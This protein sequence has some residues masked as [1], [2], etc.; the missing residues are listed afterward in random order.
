[1]LVCN[2]VSFMDPMIIL[3]SIRRPV[4]FVMYYKIFNIPLV[5]YVFRAAKAIPIAGAKEDPA[6]MER[7]FDEVDKELAAGHLVC[8][9]PEGAI[10]RDGEIQPFRPGVEK[11]LARRPVPV[12]P[13]A[14]RNLWG[15]IFSRRDS[16]VGRMRLPRR[17]RAKI[18]LV[19]DK[20]IPPE[21][22]KAA[23]LEAKVRELRGDAA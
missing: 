2:H 9:F 23:V 4:R 18:E 6:I 17:F 19:I 8:I 21:E 13:M 7:A 20:P 10:T 3:G 16:A 14:V 12:V 11:A 1:M 15:S 5:K 22:A